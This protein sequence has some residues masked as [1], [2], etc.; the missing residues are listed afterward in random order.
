[1]FANL[2]LTSWKYRRFTSPAINSG[3]KEL[4]LFETEFSPSQVL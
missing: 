2:S 4:H 1:M 3:L